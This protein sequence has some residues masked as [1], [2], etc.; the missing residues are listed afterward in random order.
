MNQFL[1]KRI[2]NALGKNIFIPQALRQDAA[3]G[4]IIDNQALQEDY[5]F[6]PENI[7]LY[8]PAM[9]RL[10]RKIIGLYHERERNTVLKQY[11][12]FVLEE[13]KEPGLSGFLAEQE[14]DVLELLESFDF[15]SLS[16]NR[17][18]ACL[19]LF[20]TWLLFPELIRDE[21]RVSKLTALFSE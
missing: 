17:R 4:L 20:E 9:N 19:H 13:L 18:N 16:C 8:L 10:M 1:R 5:L 11:W 15:R 21:K 3:A 12:K 6:T 7:S 14:A 2:W